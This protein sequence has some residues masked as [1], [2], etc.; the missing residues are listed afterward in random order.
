M[1]LQRET[2]RTHLLLEIAGRASVPLLLW[3][4]Q[5][6]GPSFEGRVFYVALNG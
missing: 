2:E 1:I 5:G 6:F 3:A 4:A